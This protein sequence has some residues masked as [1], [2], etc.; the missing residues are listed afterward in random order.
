MSIENEIKELEADILKVN[1]KDYNISD[2]TDENNINNWV[3]NEPDEF[4]NYAKKRI[5]FLEELKPKLLKNGGRKK[6]LKRSGKKTI[7][8]GGKSNRRKMRK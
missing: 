8:K 1:N 4:I 6:T 7:K 5:S 2:S 3:K